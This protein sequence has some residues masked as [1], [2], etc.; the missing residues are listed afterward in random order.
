MFFKLFQHAWLSVRRS[1]IWTQSVIQNI[2]LGFFGLYLLLNLLALGFIG[3]KLIE[4]FFPDQNPILVVSQYMIYYILTDIVMRFMIQKFPSLNLQ[5]YMVQNI[6][7]SSLAHYLNIRSLFSFFNLAP[8]F[9]IV[10][11]Y[12][13]TA[14]SHIGLI[15]IIIMGLI[16]FVN[17]FIGYWIDKS[18]GK[19][20]WLAGGILGAIMGLLYLDWKAFFKLS[21]FTQDF[22]FSMFQSPITVIVL[23]VIL[24]GLYF[25]CHQILRKN[26]YLDEGIKEEKKYSSSEFAFF[27]AFGPKLGRLMQLEAKLIWRNKRPKAYFMMSIMFLFYPL[28]F[29]GNGLIDSTGM[30]IFIGLILTGSLS[31]NHGQLLL[32]WNSEHFDF[33]LAQNIKLKDYLTAKYTLL[34]L[35]NFVFYFLSIPYL[36]VYPKVFYV[37]TAMVFFNTGFTIFSYMFLA[38]ANSKRIEINKGGMFSFEGFGAAHYLIILPIMIIPTLIYLAFKFM[39][40]PTLGIVMIGVVGLIGILLKNYLLDRATKLMLKSKYSI[41]SNFKQ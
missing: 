3:G 10:P 9:F 6:K 13:M 26:A 38:F 33:I 29:L 25:M 40:Q 30:L 27:N 1:S 15:W 21:D 7:K 17:H 2:I 37:A 5:H 34:A 4:D 39:G 11:F 19:N 24:A 12:F 31:L 23:L 16:V 8:F 36:F 35:S 20:I 22:F 41:N 14:Q 18:L 28:L 32:S